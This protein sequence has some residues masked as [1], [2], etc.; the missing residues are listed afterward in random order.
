MKTVEQ[1]LLELC[2]TK[3]IE[4]DKNYIKI[5]LENWKELY[6]YYGRP[7][8]KY[9]TLEEAIEALYSDHIGE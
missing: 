5:T 2:K 3:K 4:T 1:K 8:D 7:F 9:N 6:Y